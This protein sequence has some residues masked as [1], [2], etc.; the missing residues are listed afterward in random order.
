MKKLLIA[1]L[2][3]SAV[4]ATSCK[5]ESEVAPTKSTSV[6]VSDKGNLGTWD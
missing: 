2:L 3:V 5:K 4:G 1:I 6:K